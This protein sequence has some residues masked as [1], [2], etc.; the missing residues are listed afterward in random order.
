MQFAKP[1]ADDL[2]VDMTSMIDVVFQLLAFFIMT[3]KVVAMEGDFQVRMPLVSTTGD[4]L[5]GT[6]PDL[7]LVKLRS[8]AE[9]VISAVEADG[10]TMEG[11][12]QES[13]FEGLTQYVERKL[14]GAANPEDAVKTEVEFDIDYDLRYAYT[15]RGIEAVSGRKQMDGSVKKLIEK[16]K[17]KDNSRRGG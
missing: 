10:R 1:E 6:P 14:A 17:F 9:G 13:L 7:I 2:K 11:N 3:F 5:E 15:V 12:T 4:S 16:V 8:G